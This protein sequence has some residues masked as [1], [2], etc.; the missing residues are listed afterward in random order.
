M[1]IRIFFS[2]REVIL[3]EVERELQKATTEWIGYVDPESKDANSPSE[4]LEAEDATV[5][6][7]SSETHDLSAITETDQ[8]KRKKNAVEKMDQSLILLKS[9]N[10]T[11][12]KDHSSKYE[13]SSTKYNAPADVS[14]ELKQF[15]S[16]FSSTIKSAASESFKYQRSNAG[17]RFSRLSERR[18]L[19]SRAKLLQQESRIAF[20]K[21]ER[22]RDLEREQR[23]MEMK[24][25]AMEAETELANLR[26]QTLLKMQEMKL[27]TEEAEGSCSAI[28]P[29]VMSLAID[30]DKNSDIKS[31]LDEN[32]VV[33]N[34]RN[35]TSQN[36]VK[37][38][39]RDT[40]ISSDAVASRSRGK[41]LKRV[42]RK[43]PSTERKDRRINDRGDRSQSC[44]KSRTFSPKR[45]LNAN[46]EVPNRVSRLDSL[47]IQQAVLPQRTVQRSSLPKLKMT[48][49]A[50]DPLVWPEWSSL[51]NVVIH[52]API[53][54]NAK[55][56]YLKT[57]VKGKAKAAIAG[58]CYSGELYH[59]AWDTLVRNFG[60]PQTVVNAQMKLIHT[61]PFIKSYD[62]AA[63]IKS[64]QLITTCV[65]V[66]NQYRFTGDLSSESVLNSAVRKLPPESKTKW[67]FYAKG[68][69]YQTANFSKFCEWLNDVAFV[70]DELLVQFRQ[71][72]DKKQ[73]TSIDRTKTT[74]S[75]MS[76]TVNETGCSTFNSNPKAPIKCVVCATSH[77]LW[78]CDAFKNLFL[79]D[80]YKK[81][82]ENKLC[83]LCFR[84][85][86]AVKDCKMKEC[87]I[88]G[89][90]RRNN[91]LLHRPE[92]TKS[93]NTTSTETVETHASVSS[94]TFGILP[95]YEVKLSNNG[96]KVKLLAL[97]DSGSSLSWI[98][99]TSAD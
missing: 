11:F 3:A 57:L 22:E 76:A 27:Q 31:S 79:I 41:P 19:E 16:N 67:L 46:C 66:F 30:E 77:G 50:G 80:R 38:E 78:A 23:E 61:Y 29:S 98:D 64:S 88:D 72:S 40:A 69:K 91:R 47:P 94:N 60:R 18:R 26:D 36:V 13:E 49:F 68:Q 85:G 35:Q 82:K 20:E 24:Q 74:G 87:S 96:K 71:R 70:H 59:T 63:I 86:H 2:S 73:S 81:V 58:L 43:D 9:L 56:S 44:S 4:N 17:S 32:S 54:D 10:D 5:A 6:E 52:N 62:S 21:R 1:L 93:S 37:T 7:A 97:V 15:T 8:G 12:P 55:M 45:H 65:S 14:L 33:M 34:I 84:G 75:S 39:K 95:V 25:K 53:D 99:K 90:K 42:E 51:F 92:E 83:F 48:E 28:S 89:C